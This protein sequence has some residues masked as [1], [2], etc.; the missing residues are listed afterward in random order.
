MKHS[1]INYPRVLNGKRDINMISRWVLSAEVW[2]EFE[3]SICSMTT[4]IADL[5]DDWIICKRKDVRFGVFA[6]G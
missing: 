3:A 6:Y 4:F 1:R 5:T 2:K